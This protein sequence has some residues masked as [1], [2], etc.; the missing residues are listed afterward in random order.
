MARITHM[1]RD[2]IISAFK[3]DMP[4][5]NL[6]DLRKCFNE[7]LLP[8]IEFEARTGEFADMYAQTITYG[9]FAAR[10]NHFEAKGEFSRFGAA[11]EIPKTNPLLRALF[12][13]VAGTELD[14]EPFSGFVDDLVKLLA[15]ADITAVLKNFGQRTKLHDPVVHFYETFLAEYDPSLREKRG[16][17][18]TPSPVVSYIVRSVDNILKKN[19]NLLDG[20]A[21]TSKVIN[22]KN[23]NNEILETIPK[24]LILDPACGTG[25]FLY[26]VV[27]HIRRSLRERKQGGIWTGY[28]SEKLLPRIFG[29]E[30]LMASYAVAHFK[31][32]L[33]LAG[34]DLP[35]DEQESWAYNFQSNERL[36]VFL[37]NTLEQGE[38]Q[39]IASLPGIYHLFTKESLEARKV[40]L[41]MPIMVILGNPPYQ[42]HSANASKKKEG[43]KIVPTFIGQLIETYKQVD[44]NR[45][46]EKQVKWLHD[47]Y[48]K[49]IRWA[50]WRIEK[51]G[52]GVVGFVTN[53]SYLDNSTFP[54]MRQSLMNTFSEIYIIDLHGNINKNETTSDGN[55]DK[56]VFDIKQ[57]VAIIF[58]IKRADCQEK[59]TVR[60]ADLWGDRQSKYTWLD[61]NNIETTEWVKLDPKSPT[62]LFVPWADDLADEYDNFWSVKDIFPVNSV[63]MVTAHDKLSIG[64][65][66]EEIWS[67]VQDFVSHTPDQAR[68]KFALGK[69]S[70]GWQVS[71][72]Q[73]DVTA[74]GPSRQ[75]LQ[76]VLYRPF[77][78]RYTYYT[79][80]TKGFI[81]RPM[82]DVMQHMINNDNIGLITVR[83][84]PPGA[85]CRYFGVSNTIISSGCIRSDNQ[86]IDYFFPLYLLND[87]IPNAMKEFLPW[88]TDVNQRIP[89]LSIKFIDKLCSVTT[90]YWVSTGAGDLEKSVGPDDVFH[91]IYAVLHS[92]EYRSCYAQFLK[93]DFPRIPLTSDR[94][95]FRNLCILGKQLVELQLLKSSER[96]ITGYPIPGTDIVEK[97]FPKYDRIKSHVFINNIQYF[98][99]VPEEAWEFQLGGYQ[100]AE[101]WL[102]DRRGRKLSYAEI[103]VYE[104]VIYTLIRT[105]Y[106]MREIDAIIQKWP[107]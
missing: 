97:G 81:C 17:Y 62:Y 20:L 24:V 5:R 86:S 105:I 38:K 54:G 96:P 71:L 4:S 68:E 99:D 90:L 102:K 2:I 8:G 42:G 64:W 50:Q 44:G 1:V 55:Q 79:G 29:F 14:D 49:F 56:N 73:E 26:T 43:K 100:A 12:Q 101:K 88:T 70:S 72:A 66:Q 32:G 28:V 94:N 31:L 78:I 40:K 74:S 52:N 21:D 48:V 95:L 34:K 61:A 15:T 3:H 45:L 51:T 7:T 37:T 84:V 46:I 30:L 16:V 27:D 23:E 33:Q 53:H 103:E 65:T 57:G 59:C 10:C 25:T 75:N 106:I 76:P 82:R 36:N 13:S 87:K 60:H 41:E 93:A 11:S 18:Y 80:K 89:N 77:D 104:K 91:Y 47:D 58:L 6:Q 19:F 22:V 98:S 63:G 69:D 92:S 35:A 107:I 83:K 67:R 9:L 39:M 85:E